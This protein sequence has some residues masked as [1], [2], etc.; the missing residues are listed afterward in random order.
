MHV[1]IAS[2]STDLLVR[3]SL[4]PLTAM[5]CKRTM[6]TWYDACGLRDNQDPLSKSNGDSKLDRNTATLF[7][8]SV[9][10]P[11]ILPGAC[12][13]GIKVERFAATQFLLYKALVKC[14]L[15]ENCKPAID[16]LISFGVT[17]VNH[18]SL[19]NFIK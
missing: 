3:M 4:Q 12:T 5:A 10:A 17:L 19:Q 15:E 8:W 1:Y 16:N 18:K 6:A 14:R 11:S 13:L 7:F 9:F 2:A